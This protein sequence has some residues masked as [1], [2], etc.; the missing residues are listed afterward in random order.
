MLGV[1]VLQGAVLE[2]GGQTVSISSELKFEPGPFS[3][4]HLDESGAAPCGPLNSSLQTSFQL[5][6]PLALATRNV[7][8]NKEKARVLS[9]VEQETKGQKTK[10][11]CDRVEVAGT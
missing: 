9:I 8:N 11:C 10:A 6:W 4:A 5:V 2:P 3:K 1:L 7:V